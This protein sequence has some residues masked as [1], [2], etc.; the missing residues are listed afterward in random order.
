M[1]AMAMEVPCVSTHIAGIPELIRDGLDGILVPASSPGDLASALLQLIED[2]PLRRG[3]GMA[4]AKRV[5]EFYNL[6]RNADILA[7]TLNQYLIPG[8]N[9]LRKQ[10]I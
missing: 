3:L 5:N 7:D 2:E 6:N 4:G 9:E 1:E 10:G 8:L